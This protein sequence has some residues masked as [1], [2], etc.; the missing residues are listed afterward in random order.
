MVLSTRTMYYRPAHNTRPPPHVPQIAARPP[1]LTSISYPQAP[2]LLATDA[3]G[4]P[5]FG[6]PW[7]RSRCLLPAAFCPSSLR[8]DADA[9]SVRQYPNQLYLAASC[10]VHRRRVSSQAYT[11]TSLPFRLMSALAR[12]RLMSPG[13]LVSSVAASTPTRTSSVATAPQWRSLIHLNRS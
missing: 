13:R 5:I 10:R 6:G 3:T 11:P 8:T 4:V 7:V 1:V 2:T 12:S 9:E